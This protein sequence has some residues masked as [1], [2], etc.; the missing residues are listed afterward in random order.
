MVEKRVFIIHEFIDFFVIIGSILGVTGTYWDIYY[1]IIYGR[2]SFWIKPHLIVYL[3]VLIVFLS[4][5]IGLIYNHNIKNKR[6]AKGFF[7]ATLTIF[8]SVTLQIISA[9]IDDLWHKIFGLDV[10]VWSPPHLILIFFGIMISLSFIY[11]QRLY[12]HIAKLDKIKRLTSDEIKLELMCAIALIGFSIIIAEFEFYKIIPIN[13]IS[14]LRP[15]WIYLSL[16]SII[17][18]FILTLA[19]TVIKTKWSALRISLFYIIIRLLTNIIF[20]NKS[21]PITPFLIIIPALFFDI[22]FDKNNYKI[23]LTSIIFSLI[24]YIT[25]TIYLLIIK[26]NKFIPKTSFEVFSTIIFSSIVALIAYFIG[27]RIIDNINKYH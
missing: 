9:Y 20:L 22:I 27:N 23:V 2:E 17:F 26:A 4:S 6:L 12:I 3:G 14:Q 1:H 10:S 7:Y 18:I 5:L 15:S 8:L 21:W 19:K 25:Q 11:F 24:F 13:H 16:M